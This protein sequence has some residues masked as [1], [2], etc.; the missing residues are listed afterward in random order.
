MQFQKK[1]DILIDDATSHFTTDVVCQREDSA[2]PENNKERGH[3]IIVSG[4]GS[5][6]TI[7]VSRGWFLHSFIHPSAA[8]LSLK[9]L[10]SPALSTKEPVLRHHL[11]PIAPLQFHGPG[12]YLHRCAEK[13]VAYVIVNVQM[14]STI[15]HELNTFACCGP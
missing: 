12:F 2:H 10:S 8:A 4:I 7:A 5:C 13:V 15:N 9:T 1:Q 14:Q 3:P 11:H 6:R